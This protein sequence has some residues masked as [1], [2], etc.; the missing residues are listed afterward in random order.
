MHLHRFRSKSARYCLGLLVLVNLWAL[1][2]VAQN[3]VSLTPVTH[4]TLDAHNCYPYE[5]QWSDRIDRALAQGFPVAIEQDLFWYTDPKTGDS[6]SLLAHTNVFHGDEPS[7]ETYFFER[8]RPLIEAELLSP[9]PAKWPLIT[10]NLDIKTDEV[11]HLR[12]I[13]ATL[14][15]YQ[16][17]LTTAVN[18][19]NPSQVQSLHPGPVLVLAGP[20]DRLEQVFHKDVPV[21]APL[22]VFGAVHTVSTSS[23][24]APEDLERESATNYRRWWNNSW[25]TV[26]AGGPS[27]SAAWTS[28][29]EERLRAMVRQAHDRGLWIR[30]YTLD[31]ATP[32]QQKRNGWFKTYNFPSLPA[33]EMRWSAALR[34]GV[35]YLA[36]DQYEELKRIEDTR[37]TTASARSGGQSP[38]THKNSELN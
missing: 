37:R 22:L 14:Q 29:G 7:L 10:L 16:T 11:E 23:F 25:S 18:A 13:Y 31:G 36:T 5:G 8:I 21:G 30:F 3:Q 38:S 33:A 28:Q 24:V 4:T 15:R 32:E 2:S 17:W 19:A 9:Q 34:A 12:S 26:E 20:S 6:R 1:T 27:K 35:D